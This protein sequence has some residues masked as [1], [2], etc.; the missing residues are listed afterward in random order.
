MILNLVAACAVAPPVLAVSRAT[1]D[2]TPPEPLPLGGYTERRGRKMEGVGYPLMLRTLVLRG[3][4]VEVVVASAEML[5]VP[6]SLVREVRKR[7]PAGTR[8]FLTATHTHCAPDSQMLN[9]R[10]TLTIP[11]IAP[12][13]PKWLD[14]YAERLAG[15][16]RQALE[17]RR[18]PFA[19]IEARQATVARNR[20]RRPGA[21]PDPTYT[22][23]RGLFAHYAAHAT[24]YPAEQNKTRGDWPG[25]LADRLKLPVL[26]GAIGDVSP[27]V[28]EGTPGE[29]VAKMAA[30][31]EGAGSGPSAFRLSGPVGWTEVPIPLAKPRPHPQFAR[32]NRIPEVLAQAAVDRFAPTEATIT[33]FR[34]GKLAVVGVPGEPTSEL[35][36]R[37]QARGRA[38]GFREVLVVSH[39]NGWMGYILS[40]R[41]YDRGGYEANLAFHG[42]LQANA[43]VDAG[44]LA[45]QNLRQ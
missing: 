44:I 36:R 20:G 10:M 25:A 16:I 31:L 7:L 21:Q 3:N 12:F 4:D 28:D 43:V 27:A 45:L 1:T 5:T 40:P 33:A 6:E 9:E 29:R 34:V 8:L 19:P 17:S 39:V 32:T 37:I 24:I 18:E 23:V 2:I 15:G 14:W 35:G 38:M 26:I 42:R 41:D 30:D 11:G 13:A 22:L